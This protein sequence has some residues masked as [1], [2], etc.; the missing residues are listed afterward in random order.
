M[1]WP[2]SVL[3]K[4]SKFDRKR[5]F[6]QLPEN[7]K[8]ILILGGII[9]PL[10]WVGFHYFYQKNSMISLFDESTEGGRISPHSVAMRRLFHSVLRVSCFFIQSSADTEHTLNYK[11]DIM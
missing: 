9:A 11:T 10:L 6:T 2:E 5:K 1:F 8:L 4:N 3:I 7:L